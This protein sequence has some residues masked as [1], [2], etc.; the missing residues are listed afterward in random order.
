MAAAHDN[1]GVVGR[2]GVEV[3]AMWQPVFLELRLV[4]V[5]VGHDHVA[6]RALRDPV[7]DGSK[8]VSYRP[9]PRQ[10]DARTAARIVEV[11]VGKSG[12]DRASLEIDR[13]SGRAG[14]LPD[15]CVGADSSKPP[16]G[17]RHRLRDRERAVDRDDVTV[18]ENRVG[19]RQSL[20]RDDRGQ[21]DS[22]DDVA[23]GFQPSVR[24]A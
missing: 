22:H 13:F 1:D 21:S 23:G 20:R 8:H 19:L 9:G 3:L 18:D 17:N 6:R 15:C 16:A 7:R 5:A 11:I 24:L 4:P 14:E 12:N 10:I 2:H